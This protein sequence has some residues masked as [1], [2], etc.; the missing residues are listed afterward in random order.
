M[1]VYER[2]IKRLVYRVSDIRP[3]INWLYFY[4]TWNMNGKPKEE[5]E[6][7]RV[8]AEAMLDEFETLYNTYAVF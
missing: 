5:K 7:F 8:E 4:H 6:K 1:E 3:Y 2:M